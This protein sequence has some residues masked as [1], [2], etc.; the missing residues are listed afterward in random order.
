MRGGGPDSR[1][2]VVLEAVVA[3]VLI[4]L[5]S[6]LLIVIALA[7]A[8]TSEGPVLFRQERLGAGREPFTMLKFRTMAVDGDDQAHRQYVTALLSS[9]EP[10]H[11]GEEGVFKLVADPRVTR[12]GALLRRTSLDE[13]P[14]L[15]NVVR[16]EMALVGPRP[17]LAWEEKMFPAWAQRRFDV[18]PG[19]TGLWQV[20]GRS[21]VGF[22]EALA[23]DV[24]YSHSRTVWLDLKILAATLVVLLDRRHAH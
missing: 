16:G 22:R 17:V 15:W 6:P 1:L 18:R 24:E 11:G 8:T 9:D 14:Q 13:L 20:R 2:R 4:V 19:M 7:V 10:P 5:A 21:A 3:A 23:L 12:V